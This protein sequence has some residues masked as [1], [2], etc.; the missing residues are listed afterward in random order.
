MPTEVPQQVE[1][2]ELLRELGLRS[3]ESH[4]LSSAAQLRL[5]RARHRQLFRCIGGRDRLLV[6]VDRSKGDRN[7]AKA[8][9]RSHCT[10]VF[11]APLAAVRCLAARA[12][13]MPA[14]GARQSSARS[15]RL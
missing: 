7:A 12:T 13:A 10:T 9:V 4:R 2:I 15:R 3:R 6:T 1:L 8:A 5:Y 14:P 11:L